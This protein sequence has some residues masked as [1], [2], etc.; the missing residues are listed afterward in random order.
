[1][2]MKK[3]VDLFIFD[4]DGTLSD[5]KKDV[6][7]AI[8]QTITSLGFDPLT[9]DEIVEFVGNGIPR[10]LSGLAGN[11]DEA[12]YHI[13]M[14]YV[15]YLGTH[16]LETTKPFPGVLETL[17]DIDK[18]KAVVTNKLSEMAEK[19]IVGLGMEAHIDLIVGAETASKMKP[20]P[21]PILYAVEEFGVEPSRA[22]MV[23]D[24]A[25]DIM[26]ANAAGVI[27]CGVTYGFGKRDDL[28]SAGAG[29]IIESFPELH[30]HFK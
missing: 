8:N 6:G 21:E 24:T 19:V 10:F 27:S 14:K 16:L 15:E 20:D 3:E 2:N 23:G 9:E 30:H 5:S 26:S 22:V 4:L 11:D 1:M 18:K 17:S 29:V 7:S 12:G 28:I 13:F 25:D